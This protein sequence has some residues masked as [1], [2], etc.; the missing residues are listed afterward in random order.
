MKVPLL[1][2]KEQYAALRAEI[3]SVIDQVCDSQQ[4]ILGTWVQ[5]FEKHVAAYCGA[6]HAVGLSSGTD[7]LLAAL[8]ALNIGPGDAVLTTPFSFFATAGSIARSGALPLFADIDPETF[9]LRP[10]AVR[11]V[12]DCPP[13]QLGKRKFKAIMPVHLFGQCAEMD[14]FRRLAAEHQLYLIEDA[15]QAIGAQYPSD[16]GILKAGSMGAI[17]CFSFFPSKNLGGFGDG[18]MAVTSSDQYAARLKMMRNHGSAAKYHHQYIGGNFR[19]DALQAAVLDVK[20]K[21]LEKWHAG[22]RI[23]AAFYDQ[24]FRG[25]SIQTPTAAYFKQG[26]KNFH[27]Y[28]QYVIRVS[29]RDRIREKLAAEGIGTEIY[30]PV[31][32]HL[33]ECFCHLGYRAG[34]FPESE[35]AARE[36][37]ALPIYPE[38]TDDMQQMVVDTI[39]KCVETAQ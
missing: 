19:L 32:L 16:R 36:V 21:H 26:L 15:A 1:D 28:N 4:F 2:L 27:I 13:P 37:L 22:R 34:D 20:L 7:A 14:E 3:R 35:K 23:H 5:N 31:P 12:L 24:A 10:A 29:K 9:N 25:T 6:G 38:L 18:G 39:L 17:G 30:Y 8:M 33:Q 11:Q